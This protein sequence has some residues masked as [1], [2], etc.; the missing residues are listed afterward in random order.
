M[1]QK[2]SR[3]D[4][5]GDEEPPEAGAFRGQ[6]D[7]LRLELERTRRQCQKLEDR[8]DALDRLVLQRTAERE[9]LLHGPEYRLGR[10]LLDRL[11]LRKPLLAGE[12]LLLAAWNRREAARLAGDRRSAARAGRRRVLA[13]VCSNFPIYS[14][15][16]VYQELTQLVRRGFDVRLVYS[17]ADPRDNLHAEF[18]HLWSARR[19]LLLHREIHQRDFERYRVSSPDKVDSLIWKL[20]NAS[21]MKRE[22]LVQHDNFLQAFSFT[23]FVESYRPH[24]L[25]SYFFYDRSLMAM[26]AGYILGIPRG[27]S[28]YADHLL[29]DYELKVVPLHLELCDVVI[30]TSKRVKRELLEIAPAADP[31]R[32]LVKPNA[33]DVASYPQAS[34][35]E[36]GPGGPFRIACVCRIE[37]KKGLHYLVDAVAR[38]R[39][40]G[41]HV[42]LHLVGAPDGNP[43]GRDCQLALEQ[44]ITDLDLWGTVH[45]EGRQDQ[46]GVR[47]FLALADLFVAPYVETEAGDKDGIP[48]S[49]L[50][51]MATGLPCLVTD[52]GS[53]TEVIEDGWDGTVVAQRDPVVLADAIEALMADAASRGRMGARG[54]AKVRRRF[55]VNVC[56]KAFH[57][58]V[59]S[60]LQGGRRNSNGAEP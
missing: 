31:D 18:S 45:L 7:T 48:T 2:L 9:R 3:R 42:A 51:A 54:A 35:T 24:Y 34:R 36:P 27:I 60:I 53:I 4:R 44:R 1:P 50:E 15:T 11:H 22:E 43:S 37:P 40:R 47:G 39:D 59:E 16:F 6:I 57:E 21:G 13:T 46:S 25:H 28:C 41:R 56:E 49:L 29:Q 33:I 32:I 58:R 10:T 26:I 8:R 5:S 52:A 30:A 23:R 14:Q 19:R 55:D 12:R 17:Y 38:L 20:C